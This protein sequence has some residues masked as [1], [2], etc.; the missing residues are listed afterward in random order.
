MK[1]ASLLLTIF[2][3]FSSASNARL[4]AGLNFSFSIFCFFILLFIIFKIV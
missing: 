3:S 1:K 4:S 2:L